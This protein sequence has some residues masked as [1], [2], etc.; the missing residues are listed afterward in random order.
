MNTDSIILSGGG[1]VRP[2]SVGDQKR[3]LFKRASHDT[4]LSGNT[5]ELPTAGGTQLL[6]TVSCVHS[7]SA[8]SKPC[9]V[10]GPGDSGKLRDDEDPGDVKVVFLKQ[11]IAIYIDV[12]S[13]PNQMN[14]FDLVSGIHSNIEALIFFL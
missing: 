11:Y 6:V 3:Q 9:Q 5:A 13:Q 10:L 8:G 1:V 4:R 14:G 2:Q 7:R 12:A